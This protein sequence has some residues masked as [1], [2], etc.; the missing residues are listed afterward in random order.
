[1]QEVQAFTR[2]VFPPPAAAHTVWMF[3]FHRRRVRRW[4][5]DTDM[6]K[7]GPLPQTSH[8]LDTGSSPQIT[9]HGQAIGLVME[10]SGAPRRAGTG[11]D[12]R[13]RV[14]ASPVSTKWAAR[15]SRRVTSARRLRDERS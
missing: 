9:V 5:W 6:P 12:N 13:S 4:E 14:R 15:H 1:M 11:A 10:V 3:G 2:L 7:P 8:T